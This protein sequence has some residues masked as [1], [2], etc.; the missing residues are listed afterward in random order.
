M[1]R[2]SARRAR[3]YVA[4]T[5]GTIGMARTGDGFAPRPGYLA[6]QLRALPELTHPDMPACEVVEYDPLLDSANMRPEDWLR[7]ARDIA[8]RAGEY[9]GF[10]VLHGTDTMAY[11]ASALPFLLR[12]LGKPVVVTGSQVP[13]CELRSD[14]RE[15]LVTAVLVAARQQVRE[16][17][18]CFGGRL[19][20]GCRAVKV[21]A[22]AFDAFESPNF[23][24]LGSAGV[25][26]TVDP[27]LVRPAEPSQP[28]W[29]PPEQL[30]A[31]VAS[32][33]LF[34]GI[35]AQ[36]VH[37]LLQP[38]LQGL[39]VEAYGSGNVPAADADLL[40]AIAEATGRGVVVV[41]CTQCL[42][43][44]VNLGAYQTGAA[45]ERAGAVSGWD[46]TAEAALAKLFCL[47]SSG[48][49]PAS[50]RDLVGRDL[51]GELTRPP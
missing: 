22:D 2:H 49:D 1:G 6:E 14:A 8:A 4:Y 32:L 45:L 46:M 20:R 18:L 19:L 24:P 34:P 39:V 41:A 13:L 50:V 33:R 30:A 43:G 5:G 25:Q 23:P 26:I 16:V 17:C 10:V 29:I 31:T 35:S 12:G 3:V 40:D 36:V 7:I 44:T 21:S 38:P 48:L 9:D 51:C 28:A 11:T 15:N 27:K 47:L 37:N 42:H